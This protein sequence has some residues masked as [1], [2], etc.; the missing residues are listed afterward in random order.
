MPLVDVSV[1]RK[2]PSGSWRVANG[3]IVSKVLILV[4]LEHAICIV[5]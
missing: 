5:I 3:G 4:L 2:P 1:T